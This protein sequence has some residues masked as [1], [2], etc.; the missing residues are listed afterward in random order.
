M[1]PAVALA[2]LSWPIA[3]WMASAPKVGAS[4]SLM[5]SIAE[6]NSKACDS[7]PARIDTAIEACRMPTFRSLRSAASETLLLTLHARS[8][9]GVLAGG[10]GGLAPLA[11]AGSDG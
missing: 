9:G 2:E 7:S 3:F 6:W 1:R 5:P 11:R 10:V 8:R 4:A